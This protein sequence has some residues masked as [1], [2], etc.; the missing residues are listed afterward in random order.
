MGEVTPLPKPLGGIL[1]APAPFAS[2]FHDL[3]SFDCGKV[4]LNDW[5]Q[6]QASKSEGKTARTYVTCEGSRVV[7]YYCISAG[8]IERTGIPQKSKNMVFQIRSLSG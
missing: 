7:G 6:N 4:P 2:A 5:L 8:S 3:R 1:T